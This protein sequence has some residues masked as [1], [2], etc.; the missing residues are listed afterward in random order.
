GIETPTRRTAKTTKKRKRLDL[1][2]DRG[3]SP[4]YAHSRLRAPNMLWGAH[5]NA[6]T[7]WGQGARSGTQ[8]SY[9]EEADGLPG[10]A[11]NFDKL[12]GGRGLRSAA[13][14][15]RSRHGG[16]TCPHHREHL[17][18]G[19]GD[20]R[21]PGRNGACGGAGRES[22][23]SS[24][25]RRHQPRVGGAGRESPA[26]R[27]A[28]RAD[29]RGVAAPVRSCANPRCDGRA[30]G[31]GYRDAAPRVDVQGAEG[32]SDPRHRAA[33]RGRTRC[34]TLM[35]RWDYAYAR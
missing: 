17:E 18:H 19:G 9:P 3:E 29:A 4:A 33:S 30:A 1:S 28:G 12:H 21:G 15:V 7:S 16:R 8:G 6:P 20:R 35:S 10:R 23:A 31:A 27:D 34:V 26:E 5:D 13:R 11:K 2:N 25:S 32:S 24:A 14:R 22:P